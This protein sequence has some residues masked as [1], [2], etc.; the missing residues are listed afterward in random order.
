ME[1]FGCE[2]FPR[3]NQ[4]ALTNSSCFAIPWPAK[5]TRPY[6]SPKKA[7]SKRPIYQWNTLFT[8]KKESVIYFNF[9]MYLFHLF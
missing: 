1:S 6:M 9:A 2:F 5:F 8:G 4:Y 3:L 7:K